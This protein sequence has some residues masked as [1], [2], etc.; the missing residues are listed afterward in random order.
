MFTTDEKYLWE[1]EIRGNEYHYFQL[2]FMERDLFNAT[3]KC[4]SQNYMKGNHP[5]LKLALIWLLLLT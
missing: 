5:H 3:L 1:A 2:K 4:S